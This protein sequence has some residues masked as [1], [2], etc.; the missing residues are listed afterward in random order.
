[1]AGHLKARIFYRLIAGTTET[2]RDF[3]SDSVQDTIVGAK[4]VAL[5]ATHVAVMSVPI[6][7]PIR[8]EQTLYPGH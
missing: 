7:G 3:E 1:M 4:R 5:Y 8:F 6:P 2:L